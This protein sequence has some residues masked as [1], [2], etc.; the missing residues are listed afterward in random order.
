[1]KTI[2][3]GTLINVYFISTGTY[4]IYVIVTDEGGT[5]ISDNI[6]VIVEIPLMQLDSKETKLGMHE[7]LTNNYTF[8]IKIYFL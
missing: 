4:D 7:P 8:C 3:S 6:T 2:L 1:M 5:I